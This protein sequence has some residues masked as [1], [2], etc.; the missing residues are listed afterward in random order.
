M[1][2]MIA[3]DIHFCILETD[4]IEKIKEGKPARSI[5]GKVVISW[6]PDAEWLA[7]KIAETTGKIDVIMDLLEESQKRPQAAPRPPH[8]TT[9]KNFKKFRTENN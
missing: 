5:D 2:Y 3:G 4:N 6:T 7:K 9:T 8:E 1:I